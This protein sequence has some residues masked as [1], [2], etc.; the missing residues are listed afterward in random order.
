MGCK[1]SSVFKP[2]A[3]NPPE[4]SRDEIR[5]ALEGAGEGPALPALVPPSPPGG[6]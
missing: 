1:G 3:G 5:A 6:S 4:L 2:H